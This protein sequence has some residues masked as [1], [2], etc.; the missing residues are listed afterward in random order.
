[1]VMGQG[2]LCGH[3][4]SM[5]KVVATFMEKVADKIYGEATPHDVICFFK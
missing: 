4:G 1:M 3:T 5:P 2:C